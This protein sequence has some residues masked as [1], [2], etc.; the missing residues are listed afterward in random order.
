MPTLSCCI[1][2]KTVARTHWKQVTCLS[3]VCQKR[4]EWQNGRARIAKWQ[5]DKAAGRL[6]TK[7]H[8]YTP[9]QVVVVTERR[10]GNGRMT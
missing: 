4:H 9:E 7:R 2:H 1:C 10:T 5:K 6:K 8:G 3:P